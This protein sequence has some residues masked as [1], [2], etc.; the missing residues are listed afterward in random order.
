M[1]SDRKDIWFQCRL[2][3]S[4][5]RIFRNIFGSSFMKPEPFFQNL[6][7]ISEAGKISIILLIM[8]YIIPFFFLH[9]SCPFVKM[10]D[11]IMLVSILCLVADVVLF[12]KWT[13]YIGYQKGNSILTS[14]LFLLAGPMIFILIRILCL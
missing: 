8:A 14:I 11:Y 5:Q 10:S 3:Q 9:I 2:A 4:A 7:R 12:Y 6:Q 13:E 1:K